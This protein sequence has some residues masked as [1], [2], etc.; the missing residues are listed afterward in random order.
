MS[1]T[2]WILFRVLNTLVLWSLL[3][4][5]SRILATFS[6]TIITLWVQHAANLYMQQPEAVT[7][8]DNV[9]IL[10]GY[11][12]QTNRKIKA[13]KPNIICKLI[14]LK[15]PADKNVW[16]VEFEKLSKYKDLEVEVE[17]L[18][19]ENCDN[20]CCDWRFRDD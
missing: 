1:I 16:V 17:K 18:W 9:S 13:N 12:I 2:I 14:D 5:S 15:I 19:H 8:A 20:S 3:A 6:C 10:W 7:E 4:M 11:S